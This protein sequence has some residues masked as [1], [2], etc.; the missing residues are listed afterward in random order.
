MTAVGVYMRSGFFVGVAE[1]NQV[2]VYRGR[3][4]VT[5]WFEPTVESETG[6]FVEELEDLDRRFVLDGLEFDSLDDAERYVDGLEQ[7][8]T[9]NVEP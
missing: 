6:I 7:Q 8:V 9:G 2:V 5:L 3:D 1:D 4:G